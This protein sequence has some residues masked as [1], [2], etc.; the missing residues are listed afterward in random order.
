MGCAVSSHGP[1]GSWSWGRD[2]LTH[3]SH[4][5]ASGTSYLAVAL[6]DR[7]TGKRVLT[8]IGR[9]LRG[10]Q[11]QRLHRYLP[12]RVYRRGGTSQQ[13]GANVA[14]YLK[15]CPFLSMRDSLPQARQYSRRRH[16]VVCSWLVQHAV[17]SSSPT[18]LVFFFFSFLVINF[19]VAHLMTFPS[20]ANIHTC[21]WF[22]KH[23]AWAGGIIFPG[24]HHLSQS[25][26][27]L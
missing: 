26:L 12:I 22:P 3:I 21:A 25:G 5:A 2:C 10:R 17:N 1:W 9:Y 27:R 20:N 19:K 16:N 13:A 15:P 8:Q 18:V 7:F 11:R 24:I 6:D 4:V 14:R 23:M